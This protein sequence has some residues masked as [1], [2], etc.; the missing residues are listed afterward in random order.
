MALDTKLPV[1]MTLLAMDVSFRLFLLGLI[2]DSSQ[3]G[4]MMAVRKSLIAT[5]W[6]SLVTVPTLLVSLVDRVLEASLALLL[7]PLFCLTKSSLA[8]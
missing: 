3:V 5:P 4:P 8:L 7:R 1:D 6:T 2:I